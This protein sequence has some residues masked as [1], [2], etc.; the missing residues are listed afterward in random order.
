MNNLPEWPG[1]EI[2]YHRVMNING[3]RCKNSYSDWLSVKRKK[4][5]VWEAPEDIAEHI[6]PAMNRGDEEVLKAYMAQWPQFWAG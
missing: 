2:V 4:S 5:E 3:A 1:A 6:I